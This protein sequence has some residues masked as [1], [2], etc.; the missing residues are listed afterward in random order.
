MDTLSRTQILNKPVFTSFE[1]YLWYPS[2]PVNTRQSV[3]VFVLE[4]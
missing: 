1:I 4:I 3:D 2:A